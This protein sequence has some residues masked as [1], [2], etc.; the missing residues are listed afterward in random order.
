MSAYLCS[1][2]G[3]WVVAAVPVSVT[4]VL[5]GVSLFAAT[6]LRK[7]GVRVAWLAPSVLAPSV[8]ASL[9][10]FVAWRLCES[11]VERAY[12]GLSLSAMGWGW[13][14][15][16][17]GSLAFVWARFE[18]RRAETAMVE[19]EA[20]FR[21][22]AEYESTVF[23]AVVDAEMHEHG[24]SFSRA[25]VA[26]RDR[27]RAASGPDVRNRIRSA[28]ALDPEARERLEANGRA[29]VAAD[30]PKPD[31][32]PVV[33]IKLGRARWLLTEIIPNLEASAPY[34]GPLGY[35]LAEPAGLG[36][37]EVGTVSLHELADAGA[38]V[39][40]GW[41]ARGTLSEYA[42]AVDDRR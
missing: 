36:Q 2:P 40:E 3:W 29:T 15:L 5:L 37:P 41:E 11:P 34:G 20:M 12:L 35:G 42:D 30:F 7:R 14:L 19:D 18:T 32:R 38:R 9:V 6:A 26:V 16:V 21:A 39:V 10:A 23:R 22:L 13:L 1:D 27:G 33:Q 25:F 4:W 17:A 24:K 8:L 28:M 31:H